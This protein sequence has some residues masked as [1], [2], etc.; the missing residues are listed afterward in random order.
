MYSTAAIALFLSLV[1][2]A[3][4]PQL[5][6]FSPATAPIAPVRSFEV[7]GAT[8]HGPYSGTPTVTGALSHGPISLQTLAPIPAPSPSYVN[9]NGLLQAPQPLAYQ[10][11][12]GADTNGTI[13]YYVSSLAESGRRRLTC[14]Q[15]PLSD[16][17]YE[18][19]TLALYQEWIELDLF[20]NGLATFSVA[21]FEAAGL[22]AEDRHLI[23]FMADQEVGH[24]TMF[25]NILGAAVP[26]QCTYN[27]PFTTVREFVDF[28]Q[29]LTRFGEAGVYGF[30]GHL[31]S[32]AAATLLLQAITTE[33]RQQLIFRQ[34][35][36]QFPMPVW[37]EVGV[38]QSW[39]WTLLAPYISSC[40]ANNTRLAWQNFPTL[41]ILN[42]P[43][44]NA[45]DPQVGANDSVNAL[46]GSDPSSSTVVAGDN[47]CPNAT[48]IGEDC[49]AAISRNRTNPLSYPGRPIYL[50]WG[51]ANETIGPNNSY[52][53]SRS[54]VADA[55]RYAMFVNQ[56]NATY[57]P[58]QN[59]SGNTGVAIQ[60]NTSTFAGDPTINGTS[61]IAITSQNIYVTPFNLTTINPYVYAGPALYSA[62]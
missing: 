6:T 41:T 31:D 12:G 45:I 8:S 57:I 49:S 61:F 25:S 39:A 58:L 19:F 3:P 30:L 22:N 38:P 29:R 54:A 5:P 48:A 11:A 50:Q 26:A 46:P 47:Y 51:N 20:H 18:S 55:P 1:A 9:D 56:L 32:R 43:N 13:P 52:L 36:G 2:A 7:T 44:T 59:V 42:N 28:C 37:F 53:T 34:F 35:N 16:F 60:P 17:D 4:A 23:E 27:Y 62:G 24:A 15:H 33:A 10:P 14:N 21:D 40:P